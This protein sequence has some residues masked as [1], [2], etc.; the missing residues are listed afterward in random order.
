MAVGQIDG[1]VRDLL[2][3]LGLTDAAGNPIVGGLN[4][5]S[6]PAAGRL[7]VD[8]GAGDVSNFVGASDRNLRIASTG[9]TRS[10]HLESEVA[11]RMLDPS[12]A[13]T[14]TLEFIPQTGVKEINANSA[15]AV[16]LTLRTT[17][18]ASKVYVRHAGAALGIAEVGV[19]NIGNTADGTVA[20]LADDGSGNLTVSAD[21]LTLDA[22]GGGGGAFL[23]SAEITAPAAPA[24]NGFRLFAEDNGAGKTRLMVRFA[25]GANQQ[26]AI[27]P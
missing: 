1:V 15:T 3:Q 27:E 16:S 7:T 4:G 24:A 21:R 17:G 23:E 22:T 9:A 14:E 13:A 25:T 20:V 26:I 2:F 18:A 6:N 8:A 5:F 10:I 11:T 19:L 12:E